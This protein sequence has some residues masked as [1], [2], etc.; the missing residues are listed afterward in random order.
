MRT[1][2][3]VNMKKG[4]AGGLFK[5]TSERIIRHNHNGTSYIENINYYDSQVI[6]FIKQLVFKKDPLE[7]STN[8]YR[9]ESLKIHNL[10]FV[11]GLKYYFNKIFNLEKNN[12]D[13]MLS[14]FIEKNTEEIIDADIIHAHWGYPNGHL[15]YRVSKLY[16]VPYFITFHGSDLNNIKEKE[17]VYLIEAM[18]NADKCFF[19]SKQLL[20]NALDLGYSG[21]NAEVTYNGVDI[22]DFRIPDKSLQE[23]KKVGYIGSLER[24]KG[25]DLLPEIFERIAQ[26]NEEIIDFTIIGNGSLKKDIQKNLEANGIPVELTGQLDFEVIPKKLEGIDVLVVP[27]RNEGLGMVILEANAMGIPAVGTNVGGIP[28]AI[29]YKENLIEPNEDLVEKMAER[30][31]AILQSDRDDTDK[32]RKRV[33]DYF[34]WEDIIEIERKNYL[35]ALEK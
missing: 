29:G 22:E 4:H 15:A 16:D 28:E 19:V 24:I 13:N 18:E 6:S 3:I 23:I 30:I 21:L 33:E 20:N 17:A 25:A 34:L 1:L 12:L 31:T 11:R 7:K 8:D 26:K 5:A 27:S 10:N 2:Y 9:Y 32:Y 14:A 35:N